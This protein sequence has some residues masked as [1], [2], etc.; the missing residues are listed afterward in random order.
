MRARGFSLQTDKGFDKTMFERQMSVM[1]GQVSISACCSHQP[2][3]LGSTYLALISLS[4]LPHYVSPP[5]FAQTHHDHTS[6]TSTNL[7]SFTLH[8]C[9]L[10]LLHLSCLS[11]LLPLLLPLCIHN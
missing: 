2:L 8:P 5:L 9:Q 11:V 3:C 10:L 6:T 7:L 1:R 4:P